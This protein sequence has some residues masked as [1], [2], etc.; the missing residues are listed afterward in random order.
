M[1]ERSL[2]RD[3]VAW[4][5][6]VAG[7][8]SIGGARPGWARVVG[9]VRRL[10]LVPDGAEGRL[11]ALICDGT[12]ALRVLLPPRYIG[13]WPPGA[14]IVVEGSIAG[15]SFRAPRELE[16]TS[17]APVEVGED[18]LLRWIHVTPAPN[19]DTAQH[20]GSLTIPP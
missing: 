11:E 18:R 9:E 7:R 6:R 10:T 4:F 20:S 5:D 15:A 12:G 13:R 17:F 14:V 16:A 2:D 3:T 1:T 8:V 19:G